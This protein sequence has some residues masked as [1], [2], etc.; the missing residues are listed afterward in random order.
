MGAG[1][2]GRTASV[3][4]RCTCCSSSQSPAPAAQPSDS[5]HAVA[6]RSQRF[7]SPD[8]TDGNKRSEWLFPTDFG[9]VLPVRVCYFETLFGSEEAGGGG[10]VLVELQQHVFQPVA[11]PQREL[12]Q[13][14]VH[15]R[16]DDWRDG[17]KRQP[18]V[19]AFK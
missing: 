16:G 11:H 7:S 13:L 19:S 17:E 8:G 14:G 6:S 2:A 18:F 1:P 5:Q 4:G 10:V 12:D 9:G 3:L 15:A